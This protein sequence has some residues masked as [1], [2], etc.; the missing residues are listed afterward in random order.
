MVEISSKNILLCV[1]LFC[2]LLREGFW[3]TCDPEPEKCCTNTTGVQ[4]T[5]TTKTIFCQK[6]NHWVLWTPENRARASQ[7]NSCGI[8][9]FSN[10][11]LQTLSCCFVRCFYWEGNNLMLYLNTQRGHSL[12]GA[13]H[14]ARW[15]GEILLKAEIFCSMWPCLW[16]LPL[17]P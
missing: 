5:Y 8:F 9:F 14:W 7:L 12:G 4:I 11:V 16:L 2:K 3:P 1:E 13:G 10:S 6:R 15:K 17:M